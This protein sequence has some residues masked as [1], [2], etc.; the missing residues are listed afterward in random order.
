LSEESQIDNLQKKLYALDR[1]VGY[2]AWIPIVIGIFLVV[3]AVS[4][5]LEFFLIVL[6]ITLSDNTFLFIRL[7]GF[8]T[9]LSL[10]VFGA[11]KMY[12]YYGQIKECYGELATKFPFS[13][14][15]CIYC[16]KTLPK[17]NPSLCSN[18]G[19]SACYKVPRYM[20]KYVPKTLIPVCPNC[21]K[22]LSNGNDQFCIYCGK[23]VKS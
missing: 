23:P 9:G 4:T 14:P 3:P 1:K 19:K 10:I 22:R 5:I 8:L 13:I 20:S 17:G 16:K 15:I 18:C 21:K 11:M 2:V 12:D 7:F 6:R